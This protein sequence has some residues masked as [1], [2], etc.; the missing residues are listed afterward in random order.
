V[1]CSK[2]WAEG[3]WVFKQALKAYLWKGPRPRLPTTRK[4]GWTR[5]TSWQITSLGSP[6]LIHASQ[7]I[8]NHS[9][10]NIGDKYYLIQCNTNTRTQIQ[11]WRNTHTHRDPKQMCISTPI[12]WHLVTKCSSR[13]S[14]FA[15]SLWF[16]FLKSSGDA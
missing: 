16:R 5:F 3:T 12:S 13:W 7:E 15:L 11:N 10:I 9:N 14:P 2:K 1:L 6:F 4:S 8:Y